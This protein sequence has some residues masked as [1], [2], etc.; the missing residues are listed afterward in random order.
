MKFTTQ[1]PLHL[2]FLATAT[3]N[4]TTTKDVSCLDKY[5]NGKTESYPTILHGIHSFWTWQCAVRAS[6]LLHISN[7]PSH[8]VINHHPS[9]NSGRVLFRNQRGESDPQVSWVYCKR[10]WL[11]H[12]MHASLGWLRRELSWKIMCKKF[13]RM[14]F[15][16][17]STSKNES[18]SQSGGGQLPPS[19]L[20]MSAISLDL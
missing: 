7:I 3:S 13:A 18:C 2:H 8:M 11:L 17:T 1:T 20:R 9:W 19:I 16:I 10:A 14:A 6:K 12:P 4:F 15:T 5:L